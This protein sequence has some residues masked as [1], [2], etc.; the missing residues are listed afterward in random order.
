MLPSPLS[1]AS[2]PPSVA[3]SSQ[4]GCDIMTTG[5]LGAAN[6]EAPLKRSGSFMSAIDLPECYDRTSADISART[7]H[8]QR[9]YRARTA[10]IPRTYPGLMRRGAVS[11]GSSR[12]FW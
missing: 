7:T 2:I 6:Q 10:H 9:T 8:V 3:A 4:V 12:V 5:F 1:A 11:P